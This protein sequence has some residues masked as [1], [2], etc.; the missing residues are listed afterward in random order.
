MTTQ[1]IDPKR[2]PLC[3][4]DNDCGTARGAGNCWCFAARVPQDVLDRVPAA[5]RNAA[6]V[7]ERCASGRRSGAEL[8]AIVDRLMR[9]R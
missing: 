5:L 2:C 8:Q 4:D 9:N 7:C 1:P 3:G 6:C